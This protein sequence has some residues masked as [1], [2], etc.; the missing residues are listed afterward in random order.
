MGVGNQNRPLL[1]SGPISCYRKRWG[2]LLSFEHFSLANGIFSGDLY[3]WLR[4]YAYSTRT[5]G[6]RLADVVP[7][8]VFAN[9][10]NASTKCLARLSSID[11]QQRL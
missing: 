10:K 2:F 1:C 6:G 3:S 5:R 8:L 9:N 11:D 4:P 7:Q